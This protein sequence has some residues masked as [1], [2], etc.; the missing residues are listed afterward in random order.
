MTSKILAK[1]CLAGDEKKYEKVMSHAPLTLLWLYTHTTNYS[2]QGLCP[3]A[4][5]CYTQQKQ[6]PGTPNVIHAAIECFH[7][8]RCVTVTPIYIIVIMNV[9]V[10]LAVTLNC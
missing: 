3:H 2:L 5:D 4:L 9:A 6:R 1:D 10:R 8:L 7:S